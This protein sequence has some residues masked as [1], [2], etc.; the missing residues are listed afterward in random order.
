MMQVANWVD[1][2]SG[3]D[4]DYEPPPLPVRQTAVRGGVKRRGPQAQ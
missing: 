1:R 2:A 4:H 3:D